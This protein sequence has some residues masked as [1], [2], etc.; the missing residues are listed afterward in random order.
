MNVNESAVVCNDI[1]YEGSHGIT[2]G[3]GTVIHPRA[4]LRALNG[5]INVGSDNLIEEFVVIENRSSDVMRIGCLNHFQVGAKVY[6]AVIEDGNVFE[7]KCTIETETEITSGVVIGTGVGIPRGE[8][9]EP[10]TVVVKCSN[11]NVTHLRI[12]QQQRNESAVKIILEISRTKLTKH[13][14]LRV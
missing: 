11:K 13:H 4:V 7:K 3:A 2:I 1:Q 10:N 8:R 6:A 5:P 9:L 14:K 12:E